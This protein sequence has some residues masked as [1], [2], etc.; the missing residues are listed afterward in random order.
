MS[1]GPYEQSL[2]DR[3][4]TARRNL[5]GKV[6]VSVIQR[7]AEISCDPPSKRPSEPEPK[8]FLIT[9]IEEVHHPLHWHLIIDEICKKHKISLP[10]IRGNQRSREVVAARF[11]AYYRLSTETK[12]SLPQIGRLLGGKD[13]TSVLHG[14]RKYKLRMEA[15]A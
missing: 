4:I 1:V 5:V 2:R 15:V 14:I 11:E 6:S 9:S 7:L 13:H 8:R 12:F 3:A 10:E